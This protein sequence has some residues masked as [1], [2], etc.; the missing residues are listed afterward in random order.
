[1]FDLLMKVE[2]KKNCHRHVPSLVVLKKNQLV[3]TVSTE[4][5][6]CTQNSQFHKFIVA[7]PPFMP[8]FRT[9]RLHHQIFLEILC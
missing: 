3:L 2:E 7:S 6:K 4:S 9:C 8:S 1:M 5:K